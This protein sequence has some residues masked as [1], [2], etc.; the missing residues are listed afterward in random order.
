MFTSRSW[1]ILPFAISYT[2]MVTFKI[3]FAVFFVTLLVL[4]Q[5]VMPLS[6]KK[7]TGGWRTMLR[8]NS[9]IYKRPPAASYV[10]FH[11][12]N[13]TGRLNS[14]TR[15]DGYSV[16]FIPAGDC[17]KKIKGYGFKALQKNVKASAEY[18]PLG[19]CLDQSSMAK[20]G[21]Q[22]IGLCYCDPED[23]HCVKP[24]DEQNR[25]QSRYVCFSS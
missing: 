3:Q 7:P 25:P 17:A 24:L 13:W 23:E 22:V 9:Y 2:I 5:P 1:S 8:L 10:H 6:L 21:K 19:P 14:P 12:Y 15:C 11:S 18:P 4:F 16:E 20:L